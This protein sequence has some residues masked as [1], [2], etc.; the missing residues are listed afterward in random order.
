[1]IRKNILCLLIIVEYANITENKAGFR[2]AFRGGLRGRLRGGST[3]SVTAF[4]VVHASKHF[5]TILIF[6]KQNLHDPYRAIY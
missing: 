6:A 2:G 1:M 4:N 3:G 5:L